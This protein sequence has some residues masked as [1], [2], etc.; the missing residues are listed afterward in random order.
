MVNHGKEQRFRSG[1]IKSYKTFYRWKRPLT[2]SVF[3]NKLQ[4]LSWVES[5]QCNQWNW[6]FFP[7]GMVTRFL[8][9]FRLGL[10]VEK[11]IFFSY[12]FGWH[13]YCF[14]MEIYNEKV[15]QFQTDFPRKFRYLFIQS[16]GV[17]TFDIVFECIVHSKT[18]KICMH[19]MWCPTAI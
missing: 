8:S 4:F 9:I 1:K 13:R 15:Y 11:M 10:Y 6:P 5:W 2:T 12:Y 16:C 3:D 7:R 14:S 18:M 19:I 17:T